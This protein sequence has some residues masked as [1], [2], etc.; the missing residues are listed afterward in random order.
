MPRYVVR[1]HSK[2]SGQCVVFDT[3][4]GKA[5]VQPGT[6]KDPEDDSMSRAYA[7][8]LAARLNRIYEMLHPTPS[9]AVNA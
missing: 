9:L 3:R 2:F 7:T 1:D 5:V 4:I 6:G 8:D